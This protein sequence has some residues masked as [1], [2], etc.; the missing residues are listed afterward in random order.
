MKY[1]VNINEF[2]GPLDLLLHLIKK[3]NISINEISI[4]EI[5]KQYLEYI[6]KME[7][8][9][10]DIASEYL[11]MAAELIEIKSSSLLPRQ[12]IEEDEFEEDPKEKL[13]KRLLEY[14]QYKNLTGTFK[15]LEEYRK[16]IYTKE[17]DNMLEYKDSN[18]NTDYGVDLNDLIEAFSKFL[19]EKELDKP[20]A[21]KVSTKEYSVG[22]RSF[23]IRNILKK[24]KKIEFSELFDICTKEYIVVTFLAILAMSRKQE[25][26]IE[27]E[28]N[29]KNIIIKEKGVK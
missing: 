20:L 5:T 11:V 9:N 8:L 17:P 7:E 10:L 1:E 2:E 19:K 29:F 15:E 21:T 13:I 25:I 22:K 18:N 26:D 27:Q 12:E 6:N 3:S 14:E 28:S 23:E 16:E 24:K 4:D